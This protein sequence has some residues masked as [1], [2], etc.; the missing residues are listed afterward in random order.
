MSLLSGDTRW[1]ESQEPQN[2]LNE[3]VVSGYSHHPMVAAV[4]PDYLT[5]AITWPHTFGAVKESFEGAALV[6]GDV[7]RLMYVNKMT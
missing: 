4:L 6:H 7:G 5:L 3:L 2:W 1:V